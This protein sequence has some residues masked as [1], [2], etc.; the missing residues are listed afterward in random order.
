MGHLLGFNE[1]E[2]NHKLVDLL[3]LSFIQIHIY[4]NLTINKSLNLDMLFK[5][6]ERDFRYSTL[7]GLQ[8][9]RTVDG[10]PAR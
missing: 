10:P 1:N 4:E 3:L 7:N 6:D 8:N 2:T 5:L 9:V